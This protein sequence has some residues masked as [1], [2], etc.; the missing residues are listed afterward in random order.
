MIQLILMLLGLSF[1]ND[2]IQNTNSNSQTS[3]TIY[4]N[5]TSGEGLDT[6]GDTGHVLPP[7]K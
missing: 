3:V 6:G 7:K 4:N 2:N 5:T 1:P